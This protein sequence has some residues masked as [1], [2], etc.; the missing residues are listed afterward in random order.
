MTSSIPEPLH[1]QVYLRLRTSILAGKIAQGDRLTENRLAAQL[2]VSR[3]P[4]REAIRRL[5]YEGLLTLDSAAGVTPVEIALEDALH[6]YDCRIALEQLAVEGACRSATP[7]QLDSLR[8]ILQEA[9]GLLQQTSQADSSPAIA[10]HALKQRDLNYAFHRLIAESSQNRW[11]VS[12]LDQLANQVKLLRL[13]ILQVPVDIEAIQS[14]HWQLVEA[15]AQHDVEAAVGY[16]RQHL[17]VS[18]QRIAKTIERQ[19]NAL[20]VQVAREETLV[21]CPRCRSQDVKKNG[22]R[23][24]KQNYLCKACGRQFVES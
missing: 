10:D 1:E 15:I 22:R 16:M 8:R 5:Q 24:R 9:D 3:T 20:P 13:Q 6:L 21:I 19:A 23:K 17:E 14:E 7:T 2:Q 18:K 4:V 11:L 12:I